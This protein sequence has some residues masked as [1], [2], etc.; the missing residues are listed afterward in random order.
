MKVTIRQ[1]DFHDKTGDATKAGRGC[2]IQLH[3]NIKQSIIST[4]K[5]VIS[6]ILD[7]KSL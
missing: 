7:Y 5:V 1:A 2:K 3:Q 4:C 6:S